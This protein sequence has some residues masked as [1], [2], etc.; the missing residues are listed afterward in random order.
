MAPAPLVLRRWTL[1]FLALLFPSF[2]RYA[3]LPGPVELTQGQRA[4]QRVTGQAQEAAPT[5]MS[6]GNEC[7]HLGSWVGICRVV[8][9]QIGLQ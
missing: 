7:H 3:S 8:L 2:L 4:H 1:P 6:P 5:R 9:S